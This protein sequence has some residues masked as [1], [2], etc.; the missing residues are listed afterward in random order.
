MGYEVSCLERG[1]WGGILG[2]REGRRFEVF[3][4]LGFDDRI[5]L[6]CWVLKRKIRFLG[7]V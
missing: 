1:V 2:L 7:L 3:I 4:G 5:Y 6:G